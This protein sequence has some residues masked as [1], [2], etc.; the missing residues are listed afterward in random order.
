MAAEPAARIVAHDDPAV[1]DRVVAA[2]RAGAVVVLPTDPVYGLVA[3]PQDERATAQV[4]TLK[5]RAAAVPIAVLCADVTQAL[6]LAATDVDP[7][8]GPV[9]ARWWPGPLTLVVPRRSG[10]Q[11]HLGEPT[12]TIGLR[13][14]DHDL[15]RR[16]AAAVGPLA[17]TSA[18][19]HGQPPASTAA[20]AL[21]ALGTGVALAVDGGPLADGASTVIDATARPWHVLREG[22][23]SG[24]DVVS[25]A[26]AVAADG[27]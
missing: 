5:G 6:Q 15:I 3:L 23:I 27:G 7:A 20:E 18:N 9:A 8:V 24:E 16:I 25:L 1:V 22:P 19:L 4:L 10:V 11:L 13:V 26:G 17:A 2:L 21:E 14:P 12:T